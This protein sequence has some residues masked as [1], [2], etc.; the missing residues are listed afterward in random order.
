MKKIIL[1]SILSVLIHSCSTFQFRNF[2]K[3]KFTNL[4]T[5]SF[6]STLTK[7]VNNGD[8]KDS[9]E[10]VNFS[11]NKPI[12]IKQVSHNI[13]VDSSYINNETLL[14]D[15][16]KVNKI[17]PKV[18]NED[19]FLNIN[20][21][22]KKKT[23]KRY[24]NVVSTHNLKQLYSKR[25]AFF[26]LILLLFP[27]LFIKNIGFKIAYWGK[28]NVKKAQILIG[29]F[30]VTGLFSSYLLGCVVDF[31]VPKFMIL[32]TLALG[33]LSL[34]I[35]NIKTKRHFFKNK[36][37]LSM[38][39]TSSLFMSFMAGSNS[40]FHLFSPSNEMVVHPALAIFLTILIIGLLALSLYGLA[41]LACQIGCAGYEF[42]AG[43][44]FFGGAF[45]FIFLA[46]FAIYK[47]FRRK[48]EKPEK[49]PKTKEEEAEKII[50]TNRILLILIIVL[51]FILMLIL[52]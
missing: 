41:A 37:A 21:T 25:G 34:L 7:T 18:V 52:F 49:K 45:G 44:V 39:S 13:A 48:K 46:V 8:N 20:H 1:I 17:R 38:F 51:I 40:N 16:H 50:K 5:K 23:H 6:K 2:N 11:T 14:N 19:A 15:N 31:T 10:K 4:K 32:V 22:L 24:R 12:K 26:F 9:I 35:N 33:L 28:N 27:L 47:L 29:V 43:V 42:L 36:L 30:T 3:Q